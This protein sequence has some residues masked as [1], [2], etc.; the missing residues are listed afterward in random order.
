[1]YVYLKSRKNMLGIS[2]FTR[3]NEVIV[4]FSPYSYVV[5]D[6]SKIILLQGSLKNG[7]YQVMTPSTTS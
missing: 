5:N 3:D 1:M 2:K 4:E 6:E 7:L